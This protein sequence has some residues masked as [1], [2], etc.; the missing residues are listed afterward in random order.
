MRTRRGFTLIEL[1][2]AM[3]IAALMFAMGYG[4]IRQAMNDRVALKE[5]QDRLL[6]VQTTMRVI[7]QDFI[8]LAPRPTRDPVGTTYQ[9]A[10]RGQ[11]GAQPLA[12][13][14][15]GGWSNP[16]GIPRP[17]LQRVSYVLENGKL[18]RESFQVL[19][20]VLASTVVKRELIDQ[21]RSV[22][23]RYMSDNH[24]W[25]EDW[26]AQTNTQIVGGDRTRP[27]AVEITIDLEDWGRIVR[28]V[29]VAV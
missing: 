9:P 1:V 27:I 15:R 20:A 26:P 12:S 10:L 23:F 8:Q 7:T 4:A 13:L 17:Q 18:R 19:D 25:R 24:T 14:T 16:A 2:V 11:A 5:R 29:E 21:V 28:V 6:A 22:T 3:F